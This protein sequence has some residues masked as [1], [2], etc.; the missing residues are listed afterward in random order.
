MRVLEG[1]GTL[2]QLAALLARMCRVVRLKYTTVDAAVLTH[3]TEHATRYLQ[4]MIPWNSC[5]NSK[6][7]YEYFLPE[8]LERGMSC[9]SCTF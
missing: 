2:V 8:L 4:D 3:G 7:V 5:V 6:H 9:Q 1:V